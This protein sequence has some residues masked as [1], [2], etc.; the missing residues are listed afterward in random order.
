MGNYVAAIK[1]LKK[2]NKTGGRSEVDGEVALLS[3]FVARF[4]PGS[5]LKLLFTR[6]HVKLLPGGYPQ[7]F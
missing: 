5:V 1:G 7:F 2:S 3:R 6:H 4:V